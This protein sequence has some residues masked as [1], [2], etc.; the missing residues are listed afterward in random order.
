MNW[1]ILLGFAAAICT[2]ISFLPQVIKTVR[3]KHTKDLSLIMYSVVAIGFVLWLTYGIII[4]DLPL[5]LANTISLL[6]ALTILVFKIR[7]K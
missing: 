6:L 2:T 3:T 7:Y 5:I 4:S 1:I